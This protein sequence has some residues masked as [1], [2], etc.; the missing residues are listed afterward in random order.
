M[1]GG[2]IA[3]QSFWASVVNYSGSLLGLFTTFYVFPLVFSPA[4]FGVT[5]VFI[6][7]GALLAAVAQLGTGYS[8][9][10]FFPRFKDEKGHHGAGFWLL[11]VPAFG[12]L[13]LGVAL[14]GFKSELLG[15]F[16]ANAAQ[17]EPYYLWLLPFVFFFVFNTVF[18]TFS[19]SLGHIIF[20][21]FLRENV[22]RI[23]LGGLGFLYY[24]KWIGFAES[25]QW[26]PFV[27]GF[28]AILNLGNILKL[29]QLSFRPDLG[30]VRSQPDLTTEFSKYTL[31]FFL[32]TLANLFVQRL[33]MLMVS[34][35]KGWADSGVYAIAINM[36]VL[37][38]VPTR[39]ILQVAN[40]KLSEALHQENHA[41]VQRLYTKTSLNQFL[42]G[43]LVL[44]CIWLGLDAFYAFMP[45]GEVYRAGKMAVLLLGL[46]KLFVLMQGNSSAML[47]FSKKYYWALL[48]NAIA[49][50]VALLMNRWLI[51]IYGLNGAALATAST[52]L[53]IS[54]VTGFLVWRIYRMHAFHAEMRK[55]LV[56]VL[57]LLVWT[58]LVEWA[59]SEWVVWG[60]VGST[61]AK[62][63][64]VLLPILA[65]LW[66]FNI[67]ED[68]NSLLRKAG[69]QLRQML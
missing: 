14:L 20:P 58:A 31:Y 6:E 53:A 34:S 57:L 5:R 51:P 8:I 11:I 67:S 4:E 16:G 50:F 25:I 55:A 29:T 46:G 41:E 32:T 52:W 35:V 68:L 13:I 22:V 56:F 62:S 61:L 65:L 47:A 28:V 33:D 23:A 9:W 38:E 19:A 26:V 7:I 43:A 69:A 27:Y 24:M 60:I 48:I 10:K 18:E 15:F 36:A 1:S 21:S 42:L 44:L 64:L 45:N 63:L 66:K 59:W 39:S 40:P 37:I 17:I 3:R 49:V 12:C 30:F 54:I 2:Q